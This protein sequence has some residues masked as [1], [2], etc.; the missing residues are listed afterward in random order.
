MLF[1]IRAEHLA[2]LLAVVGDARTQLLELVLAAAHFA[3]SLRIETDH[4]PIP[5]VL[6]PDVAPPAVP[7]M[8][9]GPRPDLA[10]LGLLVP[11]IG[12]LDVLAHNVLPPGGAEADVGGARV[13]RQEKGFPY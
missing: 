2:A 6:T 12:V 9:P 7:R 11:V 8:A 4:P 5:V 10:L 13:N 1:A 3:R